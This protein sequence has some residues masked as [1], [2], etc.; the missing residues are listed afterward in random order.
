M[1]MSLL[2]IFGFVALAVGIVYEVR[3]RFFRSC[4]ICGGKIRIAEFKNSSGQSEAKPPAYSFWRG[5]RRN[6]EIYK[7]RICGRTETRKYWTWGR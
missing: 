7:C 5:P 4:E 6:A 2:T 1:D 3:F